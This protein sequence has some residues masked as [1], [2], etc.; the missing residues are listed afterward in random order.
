MKTIRLPL[1]DLLLF[2][3]GGT[4]FACSAFKGDCASAGSPLEERSFG[5]PKLFFIFSYS[6]L[7]LAILINDI[8]NLFR[9][10]LWHFSEKQNCQNAQYFLSSNREYYTFFKINEAFVPPNP[11]ELDNATFISRFLASFGT[12]SIFVSRSG[13]SRLSVGGAT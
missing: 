3:G 2:G 11:N 12:R 5:L 10:K 8:L 1:A 4:S 6:S 7:N 9:L 13:L